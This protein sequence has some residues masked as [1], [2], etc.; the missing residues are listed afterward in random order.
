LPGVA[1]ASSHDQ[2]TEFPVPI[3]C[4]RLDTPLPGFNQF[5]SWATF[6][7]LLRLIEGL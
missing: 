3:N 6:W 2:T 5:R 4:E 7:K 1:W